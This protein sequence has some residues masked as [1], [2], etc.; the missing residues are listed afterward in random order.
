ML[1]RLPFDDKERDLFRIDLKGDFDR[2]R[3]DVASVTEVCVSDLRRR[4]HENILMRCGSARRQEKTKQGIVSGIREVP[5]VY[6]TTRKARKL[7]KE[8]CSSA[9]GDK[10]AEMVKAMHPPSVRLPHQCL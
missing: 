6:S 3:P 5:S 7:V 9:E 8:T 1:E 10:D 2:E 4:P